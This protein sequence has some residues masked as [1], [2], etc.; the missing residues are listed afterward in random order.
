MKPGDKVF[1]EI[2]IDEIC[3]NSLGTYYKA[4]I[5]NYEQSGQLRPNSQ[6]IIITKHNTLKEN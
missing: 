4:Y 6:F 3:D 1:V 2:V 5:N